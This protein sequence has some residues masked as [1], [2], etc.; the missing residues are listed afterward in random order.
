MK[1]TTAELSALRDTA[2]AV[3]VN[4]EYL[5]GLILTESGW[6]PTIKNSLG[7][8][9]LIQ[10]GKSAAQA[11]GYAN[12]DELLRKNPDRVTQLRGPVKSYLVA[13]KNIQVKLGH[14]KTN[15]P[16]SLQDLVSLVFYPAHFGQ[17]TKTLP[18]N[19]QAANN[20]LVSIQDY[21]NKLLQ[22]KLNKYPFPASELAK[23]AVISLPLMLAIASTFWYIFLTPRA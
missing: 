9:G 2:A 23:I 16:L 19:V 13:Q 8:G 22:P 21:I 4:P 7:Y 5:Y 17:P 14:T 20:G 12:V 3:N 10:F 11:L 15:S 18:A 1:L 6:N